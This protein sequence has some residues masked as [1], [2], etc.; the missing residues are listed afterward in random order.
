MLLENPTEEMTGC[1]GENEIKQPEALINTAQTEVSKG[2]N[3]GDL[4]ENT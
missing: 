3:G 1:Q 4:G 2:E